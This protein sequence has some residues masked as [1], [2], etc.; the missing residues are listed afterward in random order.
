MSRYASMLVLLAACAGPPEGGAVEISPGN[1]TTLDDLIAEIVTAPTLAN[2]NR[3]LTYRYA[4]SRDGALQAD[5]TGDTLSASLTSR[6]ETWT[7]E[8]VASDGRKEGPPLTATVVIENAEPTA[9]VALAPA[10][11]TTTDALVA[12][13][14][15]ADADGDDVSFTYAWQRDGAA[16]AALTG[17]TV[18]ASNT[19]KGQVWK[20]TATPSDGSGAGNGA[21]AEVTIRNT[22]PAGA[23]VEIWPT[24]P[25]ANQDLLCDVVV[26]ATDADGDSVTYQVQ[27]TRNGA[28]WTGATTTTLYPADTIAAA[29]TAPGEV[30]ACTATPSDGEANGPAASSGPVTIGL[31][32]PT[33]LTSLCGRELPYYC[34][35]NCTNNTAAFADAY[36]RIGGFTRAASYVTHSSGAVSE[37]HYYNWT[38]L[39]TVDAVPTTCDQV[40][41][42][43]SYGTAESCTC[44][45]ELACE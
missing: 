26:D 4:W 38:E 15:G 30:W 17:A 36:C 41:Y 2:D 22:P 44:V 19:S 33:P 24:A 35:G 18:A 1:P 16:V 14:T 23:S 21:T 27:W 34:G 20:V 43:G 39:G 31:A 6:G 11:P 25:R 13:A 10:N 12:T 32:C 5:A 37:V 28:A 7:V 42:S 8:V 3:T 9:T 45:S 40:R 29:S